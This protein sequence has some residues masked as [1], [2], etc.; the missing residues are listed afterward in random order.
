VALG[1]QA[2][3][4][5]TTGDEN[6]AIGEK[7]LE[8]LS[9]SLK[10]TAVGYNSLSDLATGDGQNTAVGYD[11]LQAIDTSA[12]SNT[13][14]GS[15]AMGG[16]T[17]GAAAGDFNVALGGGSLYNHAT[18][19]NGVALGYQSLYSHR[20]GA[21]NVAVGSK[22]LY[23]NT[24]GT[25]N[26]AIGHQ[27]GYNYRGSAGFFLANAQ[28][29]GNVLASGYFGTGDLFLPNGWLH[30][31]A[32]AKGIKFQDGTT[33]T[34]TAS[35]LTTEEVEDI[36]GG[37]LDGDETFISVSYDDT[38]GNIDFTVPVRD[39]DDMSSDSATYL[40]TQQ[41][42]KAYVD[43][44]D[45]TDTTYTATGAVTLAGTVFSHTDTS[46]QASSNNSGRTYIQDI[47][48][49]TYGHITG[50]VT[51]T[52]TV[53]DTTY[54]AG[55]FITLTG[56]DFDVDV[57]DQDDMS[58]NSASHLA[59]QQSIKAYVDSKDH[60][61]TTYTAGAGLTLAGTSF[62]HT[63][64]SSQASSDNSGRTYI[65][66]ITL[67]TYGHIT[68]L[69][70]ATETVTDTTY[71]AGDFITLT[72]TDFDVDVKDEDT[73]S[74]DSATH[75][76][77][78]QSIKAYV[79]SLEINDLTD[80]LVE[81]NSIWLGNDPTATTDTAEYNT[82]VGLTALDAITQ[83]DK[84]VAIGEEALG[85]LTTSINNTAVGYNAL[86]E[87]Q[88]GNGYNTAVG[89]HALKSVGTA[90]KFNTAV[91]A[92]ALE[93]S[94]STTGD[95]NTA[96][97]YG[98]LNDITDGEKNVALGVA[99]AAL[100]TTGDNNIAIGYQALF[101]NTTESSNIAIGS[102]AGYNYRG[103]DGF[104]LANGQNASDTLA[105]GNLATGDLFLPNGHLVVE[106]SSKGIKFSG[107]DALLHTDSSSLWLGS[108]QTA[109]VSSAL[110]NVMVGI[111]VAEGHTTGDSNVL[112]GEGTS[113]GKVGIRNVAIGRTAGKPNTLWDQTDDYNTFV[114][115]GTGG[116]GGTDN[117]VDSSVHLGYYAGYGSPASH[118]VFIG[119]YAGAAS[120]DDGGFY[121]T[122]G[123]GGAYNDTRNVLASGHFSS[124]TS[125]SP[126]DPSYFNIPHGH[127]NVG[128]GITIR[129][130]EYSITKG[131]PADSGSI[132][133]IMHPEGGSDSIFTVCRQSDP[134]DGTL[135]GWGVGIECN[136]PEN[137]LHV[138]GN[139]RIG[140][141]QSL[142]SGQTSYNIV[143]GSDTT[144]NAGYINL[145]LRNCATGGDINIDAEDMI[146]LR[147]RNPS[148]GSS[149]SMLVV[150][151]VTRESVGIKGTA[152][153]QT[154][155][156]FGSAG[157]TVGGTTWTDNSDSRIKENIQTI[158]G[159]LDKICQLRPV[160]FNFIEEYCDCFNVDHNIKNGFIAQEYETVFPDAIG[161]G[162][163]LYGDEIVEEAVVDDNTGEVIKEAVMNTI[164]D[165]LKSLGTHDVIIYSAAAI[166]ELK[167]ELDILKA[168]ISVLEE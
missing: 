91:G 123:T 158:T 133:T 72:G 102:Q 108:D 96:V 140:S 136:D 66:D 83:G 49:D 113:A 67:D 106:G 149:T 34:T 86:N 50:L 125:A 18:G 121:L 146:K 166:K 10:N 145:N 17:Y 137:K 73:L 85:S 48:L 8:N 30:F 32:S 23:S 141:E 132:L 147:Y 7:A 139:L 52:E 5:I 14:I 2:L 124:G 11:A 168:R 117:S 70:T 41:S 51:A 152:T 97:G 40:A 138:G 44:K 150:D 148:T 45:H 105:S 12:V 33:Q 60:T 21:N 42:I 25:D 155:E 143:L 90:A 55:D 103:S 87:L 101:Y 13:A 56:T 104:F 29:D 6:T 164:Y 135:G 114:G 28:A 36:V 69:A 127:L 75:L 120:S 19:D 59:T 79:D 3:K 118:S 129:P 167:E 112:V 62:S 131:S 22:A 54:T 159:G 82:A 126:T 61:D 27:A 81:N 94:S 4:T 89:Y 162:N 31:E 156:V 68:G 76:A 53:T 71:T 165:D 84:N 63:D 161:A 9:T 39:E 99:S 110:G 64:T 100:L 92:T 26:V 46:S 1:V 128:S 157:K 151:C 116:W 93:G 80:S 107:S 47:T 35:R 130:E 37:M 16:G 109:T 134:S 65:Q 24:A 74:S 163:I 160:S 78:Q 95:N 43:S 88:T 154:F 122:G 144:T 98:S 115:Y 153:A 111:T 77:T 38:D 15:K 20:Y 142:Q 58:S 57:K 119:P